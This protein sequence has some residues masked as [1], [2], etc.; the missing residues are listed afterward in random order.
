[1]ICISCGK[2][3]NKDRNC[4][5]CYGCMPSG[6]SQSE[7]QTVRRKIKRKLNPIILICSNCEK[8]FELPFGEVNRKY[9]FQCIPKG[10][11]KKEQSSRIRGF[12]KL[13]LIK[14]KGGCCQSCGYNKY[15]A[16]L[17][18]HHLDPSVKEFDL[19]NKISSIELNDDVLAELDKC[20]LLCANCHRAVHN[21]DL[22][23]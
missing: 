21:H 16:A 4:E 1:M 8:D 23:L 19:A 20:I 12:T 3:F 22:T 15:S 10:L 13:K 2:E 11:S 14:L 9:C 6:I 17:D 7:R 18:F 5:F